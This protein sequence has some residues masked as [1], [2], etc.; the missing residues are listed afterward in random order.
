MFDYFRKMKVRSDMEEVPQG[1]P[2]KDKVFIGILIV[3][4][5]VITASIAAG[6]VKGTGAFRQ[7]NY[8]FKFSIADGIILGAVLLAYVITRIRKGRR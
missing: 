1:K 6:A 3:F 4:S 5:V 2:K 8:C 7:V